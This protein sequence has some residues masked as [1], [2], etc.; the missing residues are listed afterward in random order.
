MNLFYVY[1]VMAKDFVM[2][3]LKR[4]FRKRVDTLPGQGQGQGRRGVI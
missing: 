4:T 2:M 3:G 1:I